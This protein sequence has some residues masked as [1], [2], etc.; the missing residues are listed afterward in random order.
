MAGFKLFTLNEHWKLI[1]SKA[2]SFRF[3]GLAAVLASGELVLPLFVSDFP[4]HIVVI[5]TIL[6]S[7]AAMVSRLI[8]Q[9]AFTQEALNADSISRAKE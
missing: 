3:M 9:K 5:L 1:A 8:P 2:W 6:S 4:K 7:L